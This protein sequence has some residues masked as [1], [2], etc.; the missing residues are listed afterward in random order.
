MEKHFKNDKER[1]K[2]MITNYY[3]DIGVYRWMRVRLLYNNTMDEF[4]IVDD[5]DEEEVK[6][7]NEC[8]M[9]M[10]CL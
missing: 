6:V 2:E 9:G 4:R 10:V 7:T 3:M 1:E 5:D 8:Y